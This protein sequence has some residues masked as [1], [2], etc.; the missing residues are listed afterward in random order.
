MDALGGQSHGTTM[1]HVTRRDLLPFQ[2]SV[3]TTP[4]EQRA[5][6]HV[7]D[8]VDAVI[9]KTE[10]LIAHLDQARQG[11]LH[12]L[13]TRGID[14]NGQLRD[15]ATHPEQF[16]ETELGLLPREWTVAPV[17]DLVEVR[18]GASPRPIDDPRWFADGGPGWVRIQD[19]TA[20]GD[21]LRHTRQSLSEAGAQ[22]S[23]EVGPGD[24]IMS[25]AATVGRVVIVDM[26]A[27]IHDGFVRLRPRSDY[28]HGPFLMWRLRQSLRSFTSMGQTGTQMNINAEIVRHVV[29]PVPSLAEQE[30]IALAI[31]AASV[32]IQREFVSL[33]AGRRLKAGLMDDLL[34]GNVRVPEAVVA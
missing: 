22:R 14:E 16:H 31:E 6:A 28:V 3:P 18:R 11:L 9:E 10:R 8:T 19:V 27:R 33:A 29:M 24:L 12:D 1:K 15:P 13:L 26:D 5:I 2:V 21:Y 4:A 7:L 17:A 32:R 20:S 23:V 30:R 25:I 34:T